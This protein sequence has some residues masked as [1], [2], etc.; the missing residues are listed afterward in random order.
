MGVRCAGQQV[1]ALPLGQWGR[2]GA[3]ECGPDGRDGAGS[4]LRALVGDWAL[5]SCCEPCLP[6]CVEVCL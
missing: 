4:C 6:R 1:S 2:A 5:G 3:A